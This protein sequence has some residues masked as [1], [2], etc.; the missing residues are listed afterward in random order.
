MI[1]AA[2]LQ[3]M[4]IGVRVKVHRR[5]RRY[6]AN[7]GALEGRRLDTYARSGGRGRA[8]LGRLADG[9]MRASFS[10]SVRFASAS[11]RRRAHHNRVFMPERRQ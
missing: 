8:R 9:A 2:R 7:N 5:H 4:M 10:G 11:R 1:G 3:H 6:R